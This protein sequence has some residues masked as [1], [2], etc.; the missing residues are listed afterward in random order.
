MNLTRVFFIFLLAAC[1]VPAELTTAQ[2]IA[3]FTHLANLFERNYSGAQWKGELFGVDPKRLEP[4]LTRIRAAKDD[5]EYL[6]ICAQWAGQF[7]DGHVNFLV[8]SGFSANLGFTVDLYDGKVL[9]DAVTAVPSG[10]PMAVGDELLSLDDVPMAQVI[11]R[12]LPYSQSGNPKSSRRIAVNR[13]INRS[14]ILVPSAH[15]I[16]DTARVQIRRRGSGETVTYDIPWRKFGTPLTGIGTVPSPLTLSRTA[17]ERPES[18]RPEDPDHLWGAYT[19]PRLPRD[20]NDLTER[21]RATGFAYAEDA[22]ANAAE[23][24]ATGRLTPLFD[25][26]PGF[27]IR[28]G[29]RASD[30]IFSGTFPVGDATVGFIRIGTFAP[31]SVTTAVNQFRAEIAEFQNS[32][33]ALVIDIM[34]NNG[35][36]PCY[37]ETLVGHLSSSPFWAAAAWY[38]ASQFWVRNF[39]QNTA[40]YRATAPR[41]WEPLVTEIYENAM[42]SAY[43]KGEYAGVFPVC[44][45]S[46]TALPADLIYRKPVVLLTNE[47]SFSAADRF[48]A[49][50]QD[51]KRGPIL[52]QRTSGLG[53]SV[54]TFGAGQ[55]SEAQVRIM[56]AIAVR[57]KEVAAPDYPPSRFYENVGVRPDIEVEYQTEAN[58]LERGRPF[59]TRL[60][61]EI[62]KLLQR[63]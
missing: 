13:S 6:D 59:L 57:E 18:L 41:G 27:R 9:I 24:T 46:L 30:A 2:R 33:S 25:P 56:V 8:N 1:S 48:A 4:W 51:A 63:Q 42:R 58:L 60:A 37:A 50:F 44:G 28:L 29:T 7:Q 54:V 45:A 39:E 38:R 12:F 61:G 16:G 53:G 26:P 17:E 11:E 55:F 14:Q 20:P 36:S 10:F 31:A 32:T 62:Q 3:D 21:E 15:R 22:E 35:G 47:L 40:F 43:Q 23:I 52:G 34:N 49:L 19:G 5:I